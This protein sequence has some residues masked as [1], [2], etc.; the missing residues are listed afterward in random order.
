MKQTN[1][2]Q[3]I[4]FAPSIHTGGGTEL[5]LINLANELAERKF[6]IFIAVNII[7]NNIYHELNKNIRIKQYW[8]G[9]IRSKYSRNI[10]LRIF[11]KMF[12]KILL[13]SFLKSSFGN[14]ISLIISFSNAITVDCYNT[15]Y[16]NR[17]FAFEHWP[18][19]IT[20]KTPKFQNVINSIYP[21][22]KK[23]IVLTEHEKNVYKDLGCNVEKIPNAYSFLPEKN[24][25]LNQKTVLSIGHFNAQKRRDLLIK[26]WNTVQNK[27][28]DWKLIIVGDGPEK[29]ENI[30]LMKELKIIDSVEIIKPTS[31]IFD[32]YLNASIFVLSSEYEALPMVLIEAKACGLPC[33]SFNIISGPNELI[34]NYED[35]FLVSFPDYEELANKMNI[36]IE[37]ENLR[38]KFGVNARKDVLNR[39]NPSTIYE[40]WENL[41]KEN[42][43]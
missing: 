21:R 39:F 40:K 25:D 20:N 13:S 36:L 2:I 16:K 17:L 38:K 6:N 24:S 31:Q 1:N 5:V 4:L 15:C 34:N 7:G 29:T 9:K 30:K 33:V 3:L 12:S 43:K 8:F 27:H 11:N 18:Y 32:Y 22:L 19:W 42:I 10:I 28:K 35:G 14:S 37:D 26:A 41:I 23:V